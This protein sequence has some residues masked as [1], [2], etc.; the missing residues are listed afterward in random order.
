[1]H[2]IQGVA[3]DTKYG[4]LSVKV[5]YRQADVAC[6]VSFMPDGRLTVSFDEPIRAVTP[7]QALVLY[8]GQ[9]CLGGG[10]ISDFEH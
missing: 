8:Q 9:E 6:G 7:G 5:R 4:P 3:P 1:M 10:V 2:W